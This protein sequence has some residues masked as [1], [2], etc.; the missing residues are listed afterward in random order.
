MVRTLFVSFNNAA[1]P[2][3]TPTPTPSSTV[4]DGQLNPD[5]T[6]TPTPTPTGSDNESISDSAPTPTPTKTVTPTPTNKQTNMDSLSIN[7]DFN[8]YSVNQA[9]KIVEL[10]A[11]VCSCGTFIVAAEAN[12]LIPG[13]LYNIHYELLN[14]ANPLNP[15]PVFNPAVE[16]VYA[17][18]T[19]QKFTTVADVDIQDNYILK[20][21]IQQNDTGIAASDIVALACGLKSCD[22]SF[23]GPTPTPTPTVTK[24]VTPTLTPTPTVTQTETPTATPTPTVT[25]TETPTQTPTPTITPSVSAEPQIMP[26]WVEFDQRPVFFV[27]DPY[28]CSEQINLVATI[29]NATIGNTY[30]YIFDKLEDQDDDNLNSVL[31][32][33]SSGSVVAGYTEQ[34]INCVG[35]FYG[36]SRIFPVKVVVTSTST[37]KTFEDYILID[38]YRCN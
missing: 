8:H 22:A 12:N 5:D 19:T 31:L 7:F 27:E 29:K 17:S 13:R 23:S 30:T 20:V 9:N 18:F 36:K 16:E 33:P 24:T 32:V 26:E 10:S 34:N 14:S 1:N 25:Q 21:T 15:A 37:Q 35:R 2:L 38:C 28:R 11:D 3:E 6:P 4:A